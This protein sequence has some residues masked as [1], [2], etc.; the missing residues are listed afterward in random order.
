MIVILILKDDNGNANEHQ[1]M[2]HYAKNL[3]LKINGFDRKEL[4][5]FTD[6]IVNDRCG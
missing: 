4:S 1:Q 3:R 6:A 2:K 5:S